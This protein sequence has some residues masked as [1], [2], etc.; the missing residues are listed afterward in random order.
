M[1]T[2]NSDLP[3]QP[4]DT[5]GPKPPPGPTDETRA[6]PALTGDAPP[7]P[8][9]SAA[10]PPPATGGPPPASPPPP[11][12]SPPP[13]GG[14]YSLALVIGVFVLALV[15][16]GLLGLGVYAVVKLN[17]GTLAAVSTATLAPLSTQ[18]VLVP[19]T[20]I[21]PT[22]SA[23]ATSVPTATA[24][25]ATATTVATAAPITATASLTPTQSANL[26]TITQGANVRSGPGVNY[27]VVGG[28]A[29][30]DTAPVVGRD[31]SSNWYEI[32]YKGGLAGQGWISAVTASYDGDKSKLPVVAPPATPA[33]TAT[34]KP[35]GNPN[36]GLV[37]GSHGVSGML[38][39]CSSQVTFAVNERVCFVE[40]IKNNTTQT[41]N[42]GILGV[43]AVKAGGGT[44]FQTSWSGQDAAHG[45][46]AIDAGCIGPTDRC[47]GQ[48]EDGM[49]LSSP[50]NYHLF[51]NVC[52][53][54]Y[55]TC[56]GSS[57]DWEVLSGSI[58]I[59]VQ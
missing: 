2:P 30:G 55:P 3:T 17:A 12:A 10:P 50:G 54:D 32:S 58:V 27:P 42:Y 41:I 56:R 20:T 24:L 57:G 13:G 51:L 19:T 29:V 21:M 7:P 15:G 25:P 33:P 6:G 43:T 9:P 39:L 26:L 8:P 37:N 45:M 4:I 52:F 28:I 44:Q 53:S 11:A 59:S 14:N 1:S 34:P 48:W 36:G 18:V 49:R 16:I 22:V 40:W 47:K 46:L 5:Q 38:N 35:A 23:T 31:A